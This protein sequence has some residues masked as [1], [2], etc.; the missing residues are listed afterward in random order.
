MA[1][2][3]LTI[4]LYELDQKMG[5]LHSRIQ[6]SES[7][8]HDWVRQEAAALQRECAE[9][10]LALRNR[11]QYSKSGVVA[12]LAESYA[13][14]EQIVRKVR[15]QVVSDCARGD[16]DFP[17]EEKILV[18]EYALDFAAE[19]A[20]HALMVAMEAMDAYLSKQETEETKR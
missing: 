4:K 6:M 8:S 17:V 19:A 14:I 15:E 13:Q 11:L 18:A 20:D 3:I 10:T 5:R 1:H 7:A 12:R 2:E 9:E 16:G